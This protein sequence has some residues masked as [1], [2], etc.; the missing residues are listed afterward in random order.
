MQFFYDVLSQ[1][2]EFS[3]DQMTANKFNLYSLLINAHVSDKWLE[4]CRKHVYN[5]IFQKIDTDEFYE[6]PLVL[7]ASK[8]MPLLKAY[9]DFVKHT[10]E[11][12]PY[13]KRSAYFMATTRSTH[14]FE[15][16]TQDSQE[17]EESDIL[18]NASRIIK[19]ATLIS[20]KPIRPNN[21]FNFYDEVW[22]LFNDIDSTSL[23]DNQKIFY[24]EFARMLSLHLFMRSN[25]RYENLSDSIALKVLA[26]KY[27]ILD[28]FVKFNEGSMIMNTSDYHLIRKQLIENG[29]FNQSINSNVQKDNFKASE[30]NLYDSFYIIYMMVEVLLLK[31]VT[32]NYEDIVRTKCAEVKQ[33]IDNIDD[34]FDYIEAV[35][36]LFTLLFLR[37]EHV[38]SR[39][40]SSGKL[41][42]S[43]SAT[44]VQDSDSSND[45]NES[46][47]K[48][49]TQTHVKSGFSCSFT[50]LQ[51][52]LSAL[53]SSVVNRKFD[54]LH[55]ELKQRFTS[56]SSAINDAKWRLQ[57]VD[58]YYSATNYLRAPSNLKLTLTSHY[59]QVF[60][61]TVL[62]SSDEDEIT[63]P[64][65]RKMSVIRRKPRRQKSSKS[66][67]SGKKSSK[68]SRSGKSDTFANST[69][70]EGKTKPTFDCANLSS[71]R[72]GNFRDRQGFLTRMLGQLT[73][74]V[75][76]CV[77]RGDLNAAKG[78]IE[79]WL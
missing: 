61:K 3:P 31:T 60:S 69:E 14:F 65:P 73:D 20:N 7:L 21:D 25:R 48:I 2:M 16:M 22:K 55:E 79:V 33:I 76:L 63:V 26:S 29:K 70:I 51:N 1:F 19:L 62:S 30:V 43:T 34:P 71:I 75:A 5:T 23:S 46:A 54:D 68:S 37:W 50:V 38:N 67:S 57:L 8:S 11:S 4:K 77:V 6:L 17:I 42:N 27:N 41:E 13:T 32:R 74:M 35:E 39:V 10:Y 52:F 64:V 15:P 9:N 59:K 24:N 44:T 45:T 12:N 56:I 72:H 47:K 58:L 49:A 53:S 78:I 18:Q 36:I 40:F 66:S 28:F